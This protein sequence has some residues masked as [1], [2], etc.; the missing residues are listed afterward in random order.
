MAINKKN[1]EEKDTQTC[2][3]NVIGD[4][5]IRFP[6]EDWVPTLK[7]FM[8]GWL[9]AELNSMTVK[10]KQHGN[11]SVVS[12][13]DTNGHSII[14]SELRA[15]QVR[16]YHRAPFH[17]SSLLSSRLQHKAQL[18]TAQPIKVVSFHF[19]SGDNLK[20]VPI[21]HFCVPQGAVVRKSEILDMQP[22]VLPLRCQCTNHIIPI[23][24]GFCTTMSRMRSFILA[25]VVLFRTVSTLGTLLTLF[26][27]IELFRPGLL[28]ALLELAAT[29]REN[30]LLEKANSDGQSA[31]RRI[32]IEL[33]IYCFGQWMQYFRMLVDWKCEP[34]ARNEFRNATELHRL[35]P[36]GAIEKNWF[37]FWNSDGQMYISLRRHITTCVCETGLEWHGLARSTISIR[38][39]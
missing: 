35:K 6:E 25:T 11:H 29:Q 28:I 31:L 4:V 23:F 18:Q 17:V 7:T 39:Q 12:Y 15:V 24:N 20:P 5:L 19:S 27:T 36:Y 34:F 8:V 10:G 1:Y 26:L 14:S 2:V 16:Q 33:G 37:V 21:P 9:N 22:A 38:S 3:T 13:T 32:W 30:A